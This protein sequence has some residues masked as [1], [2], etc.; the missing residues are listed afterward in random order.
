MNYKKIIKYQKKI[1]DYESDINLLKKCDIEEIKKFYKCFN[2][3]KLTCKLIYSDPKIY[4]VLK[5]IE[6]NQNICKNQYIF[7]EIIWDH[8]HYE[9]IEKI[10]LIENDLIALCKDSVKFNLITQIQYKIIKKIRPKINK[11]FESDTILLGLYQNQDLISQNVNNQNKNLITESELDFYFDIIS[12]ILL[13][14]FSVGKLNNLEKI[15]KKNI[16]SLLDNQEYIDNV[17]KIKNSLELKN[18]IL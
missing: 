1:F 9:F 14:M 12:I 4:S 7:E 11:I 10:R 15:N 18:N 16:F 13:K 8:E 17:V 5:F 6:L 3:Y 2:Q